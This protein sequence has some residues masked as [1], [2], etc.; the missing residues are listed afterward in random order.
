MA[1]STDQHLKVEKVGK[2]WVARYDG[3]TICACSTKKA[4]EQNAEFLMKNMPNAHW[5]AL[6]RP[7]SR[8]L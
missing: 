3:V 4:A 5:R 6:V 1:L 8:L 2:T 7:A